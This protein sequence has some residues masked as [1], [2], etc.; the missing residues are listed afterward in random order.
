MPAK[1]C[2]QDFDQ[3]DFLTHQLSLH[4]MLQ[5]VLLYFKIFRQGSMDKDKQKVLTWA[6]GLY[7][8]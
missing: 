1:R 5:L 6:H 7:I 4:M 8:Y 3:R 2:L